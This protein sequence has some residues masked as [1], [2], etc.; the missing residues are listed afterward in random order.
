MKRNLLIS[1]LLMVIM[2]LILRWQG[3]HLITPQSPKGIIDLE[4]A[5]TPERF[6][7]LE[8]FWN[9]ET[10]LQNIYLDF[11]FIIAYTWFLATACKAV[12]NKRSTV[13]SGLALSAGAFDVLENFLMILVLNG[14]FSP[15][16]LQI[17]FYCAAIKFILAAIVILFLVFSLFGLF[18]AKPLH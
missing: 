5:K 9:K 7:E 3:N 13:F 18:K 17:V 15:S 1:F 14:R 6:H 11:L 10:V 16:V 2:I 4:F 12:Q 8:I